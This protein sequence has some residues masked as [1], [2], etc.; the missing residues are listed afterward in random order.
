MCV[1]DF[2]LPKEVMLT[3]GTGLVK[4]REVLARLKKGGFT[5]GPLVVE[6]LDPGD[7]AQT[8]AQARKA[9]LFLENLVKR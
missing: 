3:P 8:N 1:K 6:C 4:F 2:R 7:V 5:H 9:R